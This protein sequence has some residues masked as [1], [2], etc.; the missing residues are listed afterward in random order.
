MPIYE[1]QC[2]SCSTKFEI[3]RGFNDKS[4][5]ACPECQGEGRLLFSPAAIIFKGPGF[6]I[7]DNRKDGST[8][9]EPKELTPKEPA[10]ASSSEKASQT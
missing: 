8:P 3:R 2:L 1:Y 9:E 10:E 4:P 6:Y 7:T 5:V